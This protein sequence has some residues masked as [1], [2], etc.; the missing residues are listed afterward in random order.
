MGRPLAE[1]EA[2]APTSHRKRPQEGHYVSSMEGRAK[3][4]KSQKQQ[5]KTMNDSKQWQQHRGIWRFGLGQP[6]TYRDRRQSS[7]QSDRRL[8][9]R[10]LGFR[11]E[12]VSGKTAT[13][14]LDS[15]CDRDQPRRGGGGDFWRGGAWFSRS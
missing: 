13:L 8:R 9:N 12:K 10:T 2:L 6:K 3:R 5:Q 11:L 1:P 4:R 14:R 7:G 15:F